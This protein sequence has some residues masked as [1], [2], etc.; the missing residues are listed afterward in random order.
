M[1]TVSAGGIQISGKRA[2]L[3]SVFESVWI[4]LLLTKLCQK[5]FRTVNNNLSLEDE[6]K[7]A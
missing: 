5:G 7:E 6:D 2:I 1:G 3:K 4:G